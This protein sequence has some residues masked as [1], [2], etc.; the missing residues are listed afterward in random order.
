MTNKDG[1]RPEVQADVQDKGSLK[2]LDRRLEAAKS[3]RD[4]PGGGRGGAAPEGMG[5]GMRI[6]VE[7]VAAVLVGTF[8]GIALDRWL[9]TQPWLLILFFLL[10][11]AAAFRNVYRAAQ[12]IERQAKERKAA[13]QAGKQTRQGRTVDGE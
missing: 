6:A 12:E 1:D 5:A 8:I 2:A 4:R 13:E 9:G 7:L 11:C 3:K 10:G